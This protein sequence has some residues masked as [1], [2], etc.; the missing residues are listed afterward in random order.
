LAI[1]KI[2][3]ENNNNK[4][5]NDINQNS[6][7]IHMPTNHSNELLINTDTKQTFFL[8]LK[9]NFLWI[10]F[11]SLIYFLWFIF[12]AGISIVHIMIYFALLFLYLISDRTRRFALAILIYLTYLLVYD[13]LHLVPN[14]TVSNIHIQDIYLIEKK[15]FGIYRQGHLLTLNEYFQQNHIPLLDV[16]TGL[17]YLNW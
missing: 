11:V 16:L 7:H 12:I 3:D 15:I 17:C 6:V 1:H 13:A 4:Q 5:S 10:I 9:D 14:Y 2:N 8:T